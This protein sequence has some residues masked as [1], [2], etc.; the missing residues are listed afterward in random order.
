M[1][2]HG[3][4][5]NAEI[6]MERLAAMPGSEDCV[7]VSIQGLHRFY[8][9]RTN[10]VVSSWMTSQ[11]RAM[12]IADNAAYVRSCIDE[13]AIECGEI[14][15]IVFAGFSQGV[16]MTFRAAV[17]SRYPVNCLIAVGGDVPPELGNS[18]LGRVGQV[19]LVRGNGDMW[20][21]SEKFAEDQRRLNAAGVR[22]RVVEFE[23]GHE[24]VS[25]VVPG[26]PEHTD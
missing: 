22:V 11:D 24:W 1:G 9:R 17:G 3:Y 25:S 4:A 18:E 6:Q 21:T 12:A 20:Y 2:F 14:D 8:Q 13:V 23:G 15:S 16:A 19:V 7:R 26:A 5:E 10:L